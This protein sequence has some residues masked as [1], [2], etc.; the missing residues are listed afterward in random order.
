MTVSLRADYGDRVYDFKL[1][2]AGSG[3]KGT[4]TVLEPEL[5]EGVVVEFG[6]TI[7][8]QYEGAE[9]DTGAILSSGLNPVETLPLMFS[10]WRSGF[11]EESYRESVDGVDCIVVAIDL[12][13]EGKDTVHKLWLD[14][15]TLLPV[16]GE[17]ELSGYCVVSCKF[18]D[19]VVG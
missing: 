8:L 9:F 1:A 7:K 2:Y 12:S 6:D 17:I 19:V 14:R 15:E 11:V 18:A 13:A 5:I 4:L 16:A 10:A 3:S